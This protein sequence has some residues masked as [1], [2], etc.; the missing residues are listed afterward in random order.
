MTAIKNLQLDFITELNQ[1]NFGNVIQED[2][3]YQH[4]I[5]IIENT[6][7]NTTIKNKLIELLNDTS[8]SLQE[9][10]FNALD[11]LEQIQ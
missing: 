2:D 6:K 1:C 5:S 10:Y 9:T 3:S 4:I 8:I 7:I 11:F